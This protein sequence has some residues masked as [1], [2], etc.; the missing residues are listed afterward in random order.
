MRL[1]VSDTGANVNPAHFYVGLSKGAALFQTPVVPPNP[2]HAAFF[3]INGSYETWGYIFP[4]VGNPGQ[5]NRNYGT[6][7][8][9]VNGVNTAG[10]SNNLETGNHY[11]AANDA[12]RTLLFC[13]FTK[14]S[15]NWTMDYFRNQDEHC[16]DVDQATF[17][18]QSVIAVPTVSQHGWAGGATMPVDEVTN[19]YFTHVNIAWN[20]AAPL[21]KISDLRVIT[22]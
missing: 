20:N 19:G 21:I 3:L 16:V 15:P 11:I 12:N 6:G 22:F 17:E 4:D 1:C 10:A 14:G 18:A 8:I 7:Q 2:V 5:Y 9:F 13:D